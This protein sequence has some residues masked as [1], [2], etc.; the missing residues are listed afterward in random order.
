MLSH[1][2]ILNT[3]IQCVKDLPSVGVYQRHRRRSN[4]PCAVAIPLSREAAQMI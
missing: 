1:P 4:R 3:M 2:I